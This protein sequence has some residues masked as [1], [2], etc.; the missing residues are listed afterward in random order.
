VKGKILQVVMAHRNRLREKTLLGYRDELV[1]LA[2]E[3]NLDN[4]SLMGQVIS[5]LRGHGFN[6]AIAAY[7]LYYGAH[8]LPEPEIQVSRDWRRQLPRFLLRG[9]SDRV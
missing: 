7:R 4:V 8:R 5:G 1:H 2:L 3:G 9:C 6:E